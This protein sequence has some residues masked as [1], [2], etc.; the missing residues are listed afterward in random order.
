[1]SMVKKSSI[2]KTGRTRDLPSRTFSTSKGAV[3]DDYGISEAFCEFYTGIGPQLA[4]KIK[5]P[6]SGSFCD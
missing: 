5:Q 4:G 2:G 6:T 3:T 1:M